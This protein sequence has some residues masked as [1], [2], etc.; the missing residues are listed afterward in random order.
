MLLAAT[1]IVA[2][3]WHLRPTFTNHQNSGNLSPLF[4]NSG[5]FLVFSGNSMSPLMTL[6]FVVHAEWQPFWS[7]FP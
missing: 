7:F 5:N 6:F 4:V 2:A 3:I 1:K